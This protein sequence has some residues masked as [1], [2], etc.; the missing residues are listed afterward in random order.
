MNIEMLE[1]TIDD[2][3]KAG[4]KTIMIVG[5]AGDVSTGV[6]DDMKAIAAVCKKL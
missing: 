5:N 4:Y 2:D 1:Q 6:V 3:I